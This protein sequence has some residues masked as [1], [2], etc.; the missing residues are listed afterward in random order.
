M[1]GL[2]ELW[3]KYRD[4][5]WVSILL[6]VVTAYTLWTLQQQPQFIYYLVVAISVAIV[7]NALLVLR[8]EYRQ[9]LIRRVLEFQRGR[10]RLYRYR[11][12]VVILFFINIMIFRVVL[13]SQL[14]SPHFVLIFFYILMALG[15]ILLVSFLRVVGKWWRYLIILM[16]TAMLVAIAILSYFFIF[17]MV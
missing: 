3:Q 5:L 7:F 13:Q 10:G 12:L 16:L 9:S 2:E 11:T 14:F 17:V 15:M 1:V 4:W 6:I 8:P